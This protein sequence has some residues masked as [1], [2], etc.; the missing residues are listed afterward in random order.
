MENGLVLNTRMFVD[1][2]FEQAK[3]LGLTDRKLAE[4]AHITPAALSRIKKSKNLRLST[5]MKLLVPLHLD[6]VLTP[7]NETKE[8]ALV[9][10]HSG[11]LR[12][13]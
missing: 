3:L 7:K 10:L 9:L 5:A 6:I 8:D 4:K 2:I 13:K 12:F 11:K 1:S